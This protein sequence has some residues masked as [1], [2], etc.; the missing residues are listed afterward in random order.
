MSLNGCSDAAGCC[1]AQRPIV[2]ARYN[3]VVG[4]RMNWLAEYFSQKT[5]SLC[6]SMW[7]CPPFLVT[8]NDEFAFVPVFSADGAPAFSGTCIAGGSGSEMQA[9]MPLPWTFQGYI[10]I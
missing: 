2:G 9:H 6:L 3:V 5:A 7:A 8:V 4:D 10:S 1:I